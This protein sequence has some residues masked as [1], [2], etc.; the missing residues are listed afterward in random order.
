[1]K[2]PSCL[3]EFE[4]WQE[5]C[6]YCDSKLP[7]NFLVKLFSIFFPEVKNEVESSARDQPDKGF[8]LVVEDFFYVS[9]RGLMVVGKVQGGVVKKNDPVYLESIEGGS[10]VCNVLK[11][12]QFKKSLPKAGPGEIVGLMLSDISIEE[13]HKQDIVKQF[14]I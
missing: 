5:R 7:G 8:Y 9:G 4:S 11:I 6:P 1:M 13:I 2:C 3:Q 10:R 14:K 12:E